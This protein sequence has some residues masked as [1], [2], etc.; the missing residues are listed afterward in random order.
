MGVSLTSEH[1]KKTLKKQKNGV[2]SNRVRE[3]EILR[4]FRTRQR[5]LAQLLGRW[6]GIL[7]CLSTR[8]AVKK[9]V[10]AAEKYGRKKRRKKKERERKTSAETKHPKKN[11]PNYGSPVRQNKRGEVVRITSRAPAQRRA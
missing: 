6:K 5:V 9:N 7:R 3:K 4:N 11:S 10:T 1:H 2:T 8:G